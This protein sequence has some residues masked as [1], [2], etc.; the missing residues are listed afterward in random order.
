MFSLRFRADQVNYWAARYNYQNADDEADLRVRSIQPARERGWLLKEEFLAIAKWKSP[1]NF[2]RYK[3]NKPGYVEEVTRLALS[4]ST[5]DQMRIESLT[6]LSGVGWP[7][8]SAI[9]HLCH[10]DYYPILDFR[11]L[12][13]LKCKVPAKY[14]FAFWREYTRTARQLRSRLNCDMRTL[15]KAL[16]QYS[17]E[18]QK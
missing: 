2:R 16:W 17:N 9:L 8:A 1:R 11:A 15:D 6:L 18:R 7:V 12:W 4:H 3:A 13:S 10:Q 14:D 5:S